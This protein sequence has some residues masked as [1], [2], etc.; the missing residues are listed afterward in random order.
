VRSREEM[1]E[2]YKEMEDKAW[3]IGLEVNERKIEYMI[4]STS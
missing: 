3:K 2:R 1:I 4:M